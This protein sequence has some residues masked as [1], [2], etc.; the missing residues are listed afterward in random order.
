M[1]R[2]FINERAVLQTDEK[3]LDNSVNEILFLSL[4]KSFLNDIYDATKRFD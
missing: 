3:T 2:P 4:Q 1:D